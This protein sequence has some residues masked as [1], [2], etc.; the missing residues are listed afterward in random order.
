M[1]NG[2]QWGAILE[3]EGIINWCR[4]EMGDINVILTGGDADFFVKSLKSQIFVNQ[5]LVLQ[6]LNKILNYNVEL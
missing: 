2:A 6:G 3:A 4:S 1:Q 5:N